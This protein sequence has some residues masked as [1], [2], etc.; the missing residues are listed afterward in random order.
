MQ[1]AGVNKAKGLGRVSSVPVRLQTLL[2]AAAGLIVAGAVTVFGSAY[3]VNRLKNAMVGEARE[4]AR[5]NTKLL[6]GGLSE[7]AAARKIHCLGEIASEPFVR[8]VLNTVSREGGIVTVSLYDARDKLIL[9]QYCPE[10]IQLLNGSP[11]ERVIV[12]SSTDVAPWSNVRPL[13]SAPE[14]VIPGIIPVSIPIE[15][16]NGFVGRVEVGLSPQLAMARIDYLSKRI[17]SSLLVMV[18]NVFAILLLTVVVVYYAFRRQLELQRVTAESEHLANLGALASG[19]AHEIRNPLHAMNLH[20]EVAREDLEAKDFERS[21]TAEAIARVQRQIE[22]LNS[23]VSNFL[24]LAIP[25]GLELR[26]IRLDQL[27]G[28]VTGFLK[29]EFERRAVQLSIDVPSGITICGD[30][31]ALHQVL[32][33]IVL[34][35]L[36]VLEQG[37]D[38]RVSIRA[39][40]DK[41]VWRLLIDDSGPGVPEGAEESIFKAFVSKRGGGT[42]FGLCIARRIMDGHKGRI[43]TRRSPTLGGAQ[44]FLE[45]SDKCAPTEED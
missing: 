20:L 32:L 22:N 16:E 42:G 36:Q 10:K 12:K 23:I 19:L 13:D 7:F 21:Q 15:T 30:A 33:N 37:A 26:E 44:F 5:M 41:K 25:G 28:E 45:F 38:R 35:A 4:E 31:R 43:G 27:V 40:R 1:A 9:Q 8:E 17:T 29:P 39:E 34:N 6:C 14:D 18:L 24:G 11:G 3:G 2:I